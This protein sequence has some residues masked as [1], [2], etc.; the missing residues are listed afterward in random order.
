MSFS[1]DIVKIDNSSADQDLKK[2]IEF[3]KLI[4]LDL[5]KKN[6]N[7]LCTSRAPIKIKR[8]AAQIS[9]AFKMEIKRCSNKISKI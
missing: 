3:R 5:K 1:L 2:I 9:L 6:L 7:K 8:L 4:Y